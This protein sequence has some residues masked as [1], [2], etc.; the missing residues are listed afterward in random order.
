MS[1]VGSYG[2]PDPLLAVWLLGLPVEEGRDQS[3]EED[4]A[5]DA[6]DDHQ[7]LAEVLDQLTEPPGA[8]PYSRGPQ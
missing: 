1:V 7:H 8:S 2:S 3:H 5:V 6:E 4:E